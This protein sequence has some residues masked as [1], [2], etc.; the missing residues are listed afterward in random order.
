MT[1]P[2]SLRPQLSGKTIVIT[3][4]SDGIGRAAARQ[5]AEA[6]ARVVMIGRN[7]AKTA[8]A[9]RAIMSE[10]GTR[11]VTWLVADLLRQDAVHDCAARL[12]AHGAPIDVLI[13][14]AG[15]LFLERDVTAEGI[16]RTF[17]LNHLAYFTLT[18]KL[19]DR[20]GAAATASG[21]PSR[22]ICVSSRAHRDARLD[23]DDPQ[24]SHDYAGWRAYAN[25]KL[26]NLL[27][28]SALARRVDPSRILIHA[29]HP[30]VVATRFA[31]NNGRRGRVLRRIMDVVSIGPDA[32]ADTVVWLARDDVAHEASG[33]YWVK[34]ARVAPSPDALN[35]AMAERLW[36]YSAAVAHLDADA[37]ITDAGVGLAAAPR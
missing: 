4:A 2:A 16:E 25:S 32:G 22:V 1:R 13:N 34:R 9:A 36:H 19:L 24:M 18:L 10:T 6:G 3:G 21:R 20:L 17:A 23:L 5:C 31:V 35:D 26:A 14:N 29:M 8:A 28:T 30:G 7:E 37:C 11:E 12:H 33:G 27:F 15:A